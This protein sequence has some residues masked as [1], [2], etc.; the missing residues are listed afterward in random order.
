[1]AELSTNTLLRVSELKKYYPVYQYFGTRINDY[2]RAVDN[3]NFHIAEGNVF[4]LV[5][6]SGSG[7][8]TVAK[9]IL[10]LIEPT[11]GKIFFKDH[12]LTLLRG[13]AL[14]RIRKNIQM[15]FQDPYSSL[16]PRFTIT[17]IISEGLRVHKVMPSNMIDEY[18]SELL[19][20]VGL[21]PKMGCRYPE[22]F[23][24][25]Q[26]QRIAIARAIALKPSL[27]IADEPVSALDPSVQ[28]QIIHLLIQLQNELRLTYLLISHEL[29]VVYYMSNNAAVMYAGRIVEMAPTKE[30]FNNP[31]HPYTR[32][33]IDTVP[34]VK[35]DAVWR[36]TYKITD[37]FEF[38]KT[39]HKCP[40]SIKCP[41]VAEECFHIETLKEVVPH[42]YVLCIKSG[43]L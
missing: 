9:C 6:E 43:N 2:I 21:D 14:K 4:A 26:R 35:P 20:L 34:P 7:K 29:N 41:Y 33:L 1:M 42:H 5:G 22:E 28:S 11:S 37:T 13:F 25:G 10:R 36:S 40:Y 3:V 8:T 24:G 19:N 30:L 15:V 18:V 27:I 32:L 17:Q 38:S 16:N 12:E 39:N 23:S 31:L